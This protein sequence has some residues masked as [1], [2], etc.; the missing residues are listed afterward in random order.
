MTH[1]GTFFGEARTSLEEGSCGKAGSAEVVQQ[2]VDELPFLRRI[3]RRW[4]AS[5]ADA[6]DL[7]QET[8]IRALGNSHGWQ[9]GSNLR[10]WLF[11]IM[12]NSFLAA[13]AKEKRNQLA[14]QAYAEANPDYQFHTS[15]ERLTLRD[16]D[17]TL[18]RMPK[19]Q[20]IALMLVGVEGKSYEEVAETLE[21][22]VGSVRCHLA[23]AR[24]RLRTAV[25]AT[26]HHS[27]VAGSQAAKPKA[28]FK[29]D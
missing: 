10:A 19:A 28:P 14:T 9:P 7:V 21:V 4:Q 15:Y 25:L 2:I 3:A 11:T 29:K 8:L 12:R 22:S 1:P 18:G 23:R 13:R 20:A 27:P 24:A 16:V 5:R 26:E 17:R 6:D